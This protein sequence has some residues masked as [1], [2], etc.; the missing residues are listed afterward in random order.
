M[1]IVKWINIYNVMVSSWKGKLK[2]FNVLDTFLTGVYYYKLIDWLTSLRLNIENELLRC[3]NW[4]FM[5]CYVGY[6]G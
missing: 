2:L 3:E 1:K 4:I 6:L 5:S